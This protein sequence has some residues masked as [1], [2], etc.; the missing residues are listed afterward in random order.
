MSFHDG[1]NAFWSSAPCTVQSL[2]E[3]GTTQAGDIGQFSCSCILLCLMKMI[4]GTFSSN[5]ADANMAQVIPPLLIMP[6][7]GKKSSHIF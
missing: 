4:G 1:E 6:Q 2:C 3:A 7:G 5:E